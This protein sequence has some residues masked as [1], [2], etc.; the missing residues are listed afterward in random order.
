MKSVV[1]IHEITPEILNI[2]KDSLANYI[3]TFDDGL[4]SQYYYWNHFNSISTEKI[5]FITPKI[6]NPSSTLQIIDI[7]SRNAHYNYFANKDIS[8]FMS[9]PQLKKLM[10]SKNTI[11]GGHSFSHFK[12]KHSEF[13]NLEEQF[14]FI[15]DDTQKMVDWFKNTLNYNIDHF[16]FPYNNN[17]KGLYTAIIQQI[18]NIK[19]V[20]GDERIP[21]EDLV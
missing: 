6:L 10:R 19:N 15:K 17:Y 18:F 16:C 9:L 7:S 13:K 4:Y 1:E 5:L 2:P 20:Y 21:I 14:L 8:G 12:E 11:I 3:L